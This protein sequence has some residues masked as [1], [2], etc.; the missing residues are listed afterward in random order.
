MSELTYEWIL[1]VMAGG[2]LFFGGLA[3]GYW[4]GLQDGRDDAYRAV[5]RY[6]R[7]RHARVAHPANGTYSSR[8][9]EQ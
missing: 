5:Q 6:W 9:G 7:E 8:G 4:M 1:V 2:A 3:L